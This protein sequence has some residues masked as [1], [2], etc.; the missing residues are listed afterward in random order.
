MKQI[1]MIDLTTLQLSE[2]QYAENK[3]L[4]IQNKYP[5]SITTVVQ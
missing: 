4:V 1:K 2:T 3:V 5:I